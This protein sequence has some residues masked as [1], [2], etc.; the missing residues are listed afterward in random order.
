M[1]VLNNNAS[2]ADVFTQ[3]FDAKK[4]PKTQHPIQNPVKVILITLY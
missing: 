3:L 4:L 2:P 1:C